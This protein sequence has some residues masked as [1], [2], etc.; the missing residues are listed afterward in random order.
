MIVSVLLGLVPNLY[1]LGEFAPG[2]ASSPSSIPVGAASGAMSSS[3]VSSQSVCF[4]PP[5]P[6]LSLNSGLFN[7]IGA[8][9]DQISALVDTAF[10]D[11]IWYDNF[12][13]VPL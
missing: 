5:P 7:N 8:Y 12:K 9:F 11:N 4:P 2:L 13:I 6:V 1:R 3:L 10:G